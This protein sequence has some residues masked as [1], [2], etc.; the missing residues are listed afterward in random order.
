MNRVIEE[1]IPPPSSFIFA[2]SK[3]SFH[4]RI[5]RK[6]FLTR[7]KCKARYDTY[8]TLV[9]DCKNTHNSPKKRKPLLQYDC[10]SDLLMLYRLMD[11]GEQVKYRLCTWS[12]K[13]GTDSICTLLDF[14]PRMTPDSH[15]LLV[16]YNTY[17][18]CLI[19]FSGDALWLIMPPHFSLL[20]IVNHATSHGLI[21]HPPHLHLTP[22]IDWA[23]PFSQRRFLQKRHCRVPPF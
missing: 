13:F 2:R 20:D 11:T 14:D 8:D 15:S 12:K 18:C 22:N 7:L 19:N 16:Q 23:M 5:D 9:A 21:L 10:G 1:L 4:L 17:F 6:S 3:C